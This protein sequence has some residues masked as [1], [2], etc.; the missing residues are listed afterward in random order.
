MVANLSGLPQAEGT[1]GLTARAIPARTIL[2]SERYRELDRRQQSYL[3]TTHDWKP[4][5][6]DGRL[7]RPGYPTS[8]PLLSADS[9]PFYVPMKF[10]RPSNPYRLAR[11]IVNSFTTMLFGFGRWPRVKAVGDEDT[12]G[13]A[14]ALSRAARLRTKF[15]AARN[16]GGSCGSVG[17]SWCFDEG[18]PRVSVHNS[19]HLLVSEWEDREELIVAEV[20]E[21]YRYPVDEYDAQKKIVRNWYWYRHDWTQDAEIA[22]KPILFKPNQDPDW[23]SAI[24]REKSV[25]HDDGFCHF[26]WIQNLPSDEVDGDCDYEGLFEN[27]E[28]MD[29]VLSVISRGTKLNLD[30]TLVLQMDRDFVARQGVKKGSDNALAVGENGDAKYLTLGGESV[31]AGL[32]LFHEMRRLCLE[33]AQCVIPD[34]NEVGAQGVSRVALELI[35]A[36]MVAGCD[37][38]RDQYGDAKIKL[39]NQMLRVSR[40]N[41]DKTVNIQPNVKSEAEVDEKSGLPTGEVK[42]TSEEH[43]PG[44]SEHLDLEWG[45]YFPP[46]SADQAA[47]I[48]SLSL[49]AGGKQILDQQTSTEIAASL[50]SKNPN[51]VWSRVAKEQKASDDAESAMVAGDPGGKVPAFGKKP[52]G[53]PPPPPGGAK[54]APKG[55]P[56]AEADKQDKPDAP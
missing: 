49:A 16:L 7:A 39:L 33:V 24:D 50:F 29:Q 42:V 11:L 1:N 26:V 54:P 20:T 14:E 35:Y 19:K 23:D 32:K 53:A 2:D 45:D 44:M 17:L 55:P 52:G 3:C 36:P 40:A 28:E 4:Y 46:T 27:F 21:V 6:F 10:R 5:D 51:E 22:Y 9:A 12:S 18:K 43:K 37:I 13:Y 31:D 8:Q 30:P 41:P 25:V 15:I 38:R 56:D 47:G 48:T 34:P